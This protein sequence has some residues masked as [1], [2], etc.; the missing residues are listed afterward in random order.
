MSYSDDESV[1]IDIDD[2][3]EF[4]IM[5]EFSEEY[6]EYLKKSV[7][8][9]LLE[10]EV[11]YGSKS[12]ESITKEQ[13]MRCIKKLT[14]SENYVSLPEDCSLDIRCQQVFKGKKVLTNIRAS[15]LGLLNIKR[16]CMSESLDGLDVKMIKKTVHKDEKGKPMS[17]LFCYSYNLR[18]NLKKEIEVNHFSNNE[19]LLIKKKWNMMNKYFRYK[20][21]YSFKSKNGLFRIDLTCVKQNKIHPKSKTPIY[22]KTFKDAEVLKSPERYELEIEYIGSQTSE[23]EFTT[24]TPKS[25]AFEDFIAN[26]NTSVNY[27]NT[28]SPFCSTGDSLILESYNDFSPNYDTSEQYVIDDEPEYTMDSPSYDYS[29]ESFDSLPDYVNINIEYLERLELPT[30]LLRDTKFIPF[31]KR[32]NYKPDKVSENYKGNLKVDDYYNVNVSPPIKKDDILIDKLWVPIGYTEVVTH[33]YV[34][35]PVIQNMDTFN[36]KAYEELIEFLD[37]LLKE[38][39]QYLDNT[40]YLMN[41]SEK[42]EILGRYVRTIDDDQYFK[43]TGYRMIGPQPV[44]LSLSE[45]NVNNPH[46]ILQGYVVTEKADGIR[47]QLL[48]CKEDN[49]A[50]IVTAKKNVI[51]T[52][53]SFE[54]IS[55]SWIFDGEYITKDK[56]RNDIKLFMIFDVYQGEHEGIKEIFNLPWISL[57]R[58]TKS[59]SAAIHN[60]FKNHRKVYESDDIIRVETKTYIEGASKLQKKK[61]SEEYSNLYTTLKTCKRILDKCNEEDGGYEYETDGLIFLPMFLPVKG[62]NND[63][64]VQSYNGTWVHNYKWKP[65]EEN[66]IDFRVTFDK[67]KRFYIQDVKNDDGTTKKIQYRKVILTVGYKEKDDDLIDFNM[68]FVNNEKP[69]SKKYLHFNRGIDNL[70]ICNVPLKNG[71]IICERDRL[72][73]TDGSIVEM[74]YNGMNNDGFNWTPLRVRTDKIYPQWFSI[75]DNIWKTIINPVSHSMITGAEE[76][77]IEDVIESNKYYI[78][79]NENDN[80]TPIR[81]LHNF[82]KTLLIEDVL[83]SAGKEIKILDTS[84]GRGGDNQKYLRVNKKRNNVKFILG[85][86]I[87]D[88]VKEAANRYYHESLKNKVPLGIFLQFDTSKNIKNTEGCMNSNCEDYLNILLGKK[89]K[90]S[91]EYENLYKKYNSIARNGFDVV[92]SQFSFHYYFR[93][94]KTLRGYLQNLKENTN[95]GGYFMGTC[96]DGMKLFKIFEKR[97]NKNIQGRDDKDVLIYD[98]EKRYKISN[99]DYDKEDITNMLGQEITVYMSSIGQYITEYLVNFEFVIDIMKE[100]D[101]VPHY[102][103]KASNMNKAIGNFEE[104]I[105]NVEDLLNERDK[106]IKRG[107]MYAK[108]VVKDEKYRTLSGLNNWFIFK[109]V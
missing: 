19:A 12:S 108:N 31:E 18:M 36:D 40:S 38:I 77:L 14:E 35:K 6:R 49:K 61:G 93:D 21:R 91:K 83:N 62:S 80:S 5:D 17:S 99:F 100:Y 44:T 54:G 20:K 88:N 85:L 73:I 16:Y 87:S 7:K 27:Y 46:S 95:K 69:N 13:F 15:V 84:C 47:A 105:D 81:H 34:E 90:Y 104:I 2:E 43:N 75:A 89:D 58:D 98:I 79:D 86:D 30:K 25:T 96:Y 28:I 26:M 45:M 48:V 57:K 103:D 22:T 51:D 67:D 56:Y 102:P 41:K 66:T 92:S 50:Y 55:E 3:R 97:D 29:S 68:K 53:I 64:K 94:E 9:E 72:E 32:S 10:L 4:E 70:H 8:D 24:F 74:R 101:F 39:L 107:Y 63:E 78:S 23:E 11:I 33:H 59:R 109:K 60:F 76:L 1:S 42:E 106:D 65:P 37:S 52:G 71:K 82:I